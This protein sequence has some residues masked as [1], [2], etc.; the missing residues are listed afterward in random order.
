MGVGITISVFLN[1]WKKQTGIVSDEA[2]NED[3]GNPRN[4]NCLPCLATHATVPLKR[5]LRFMDRKVEWHFVLPEVLLCQ[6]YWLGAS[7]ISPSPCYRLS[8]CLGRTVLELLHPSGDQPRATGDKWSLNL[9][10]CVLET[11]WALRN[12]LTSWLMFLLFET[13]CGSLSGQD[14]MTGF[15]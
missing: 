4:G 6:A 3:V 5:N 12:W 8:C 15:H 7:A 10:V 14:F 11:C 2:E 9:K 13:K 1:I